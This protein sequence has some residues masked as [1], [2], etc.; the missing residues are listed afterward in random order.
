MKL[1]SFHVENF[2][3]LSDFSYD[4]KEGFNS[5]HMENGMGKSTFAAFIRVMF[6]G[7][8]GESKRGEFENERR[9]YAP[10]QNGTYGGQLTFSVGKKTYIISRVF[11]KTAKGD[12][13]RLQDA[14]TMLDS[15]DYSLNIGEELLQIDAASFLRT[16][17]VGQA[18]CAECTATDSISAKLGNLAENTD[19]INNFE[20][21]DKRM[22]DML[23]SLSAKRSTGKIAKLNKE[24]AQI[25][26]EVRAKA[27]LEEAMRQLG[28][29][30]E[31]AK[32][33]KE[34]L[35]LQQTEMQKKFEQASR[36]EEM[37]TKQEQYQQLVQDFEQKQRELET[38]GAYFS[39]GLPEKQE[40]S[41]MQKY[42]Q[43]LSELEK[44]QSSRELSASE[45]NKLSLYEQK[46][47]SG[48][49]DTEEIAE[50][51]ELVNL[52]R[53]LKSMLSVKTENLQAEIAREDENRQAKKKHNLQISI[54]FTLIGIALITAGLLAP[55]L[56][57]G[58]R[59]VIF[60][61]A[62]GM[63][64]FSIY[65]IR[66]N[67]KYMDNPALVRMRQACEEDEEK[68]A[69]T[70]RQ[71]RLFFAKLQINYE[72][73][74]AGQ[75]L[76]V[77]KD[78]VWEYGNL[79][80]KKGDALTEEE[81]AEYQ[82][83]TELLHTFLQTYVEAPTEPTS[84]IAYMSLLK[85]MEQ[86]LSAYEKIKHEYEASKSRKCAWEEKQQ[87]QPERQSIQDM[88]QPDVYK[89]Q[90]ASLREQYED[91]M[92]VLAEYTR[93]L[94]DK[95]EEFDGLIEK[96]EKLESL[97]EEVISLTEKCDIIKKTQ[98][99]LTKAKESFTA[100]YTK[101]LLD[102][103]EKYYRLISDETAG[104]YALD[105]NL[106]I[107][108]KEQGIYRD[109]RHMSS[110][111]Q[112]LIGL[113]MRMAMVDAMYQQEK[114]FIILDDPFVNLDE[115]KLQGTERFLEKLSDNYQVIYFTCHESRAW[116]ERA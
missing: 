103:F 67:S 52:C 16:V 72:E 107:E 80:A 99:F 113:C 12:V 46:F 42:V 49:P 2:G 94:D 39:G 83:K 90:L 75:T 98:T 53:Q 20:V 114:P 45:L 4:F 23:N 14:E 24:I 36:Q 35:L 10:W 40:L 8:Q 97:R 7:F 60:V 106:N 101:P 28:E 92:H 54:I 112:D 66:K 115:K 17:Y 96:E 43:R 18:E 9:F 95:T 1:L 79:S 88:E 78:E 56:S 81:L 76:Q 82:S 100:R 74:K 89:E 47:A 62:I 27:A 6:F 55:P 116:S 19:D 111:Y 61:C 29:K 26:E 15:H 108:R 84:W 65:T 41:R 77:L 31:E 86:R 105:A 50:K 63:I 58:V 59:I 91:E 25:T 38:A 5:I 110:G 22:T 32:H 30:R 68:I 93:Q 87:M 3:K 104:A 34:T 11:G 21:V 109:M 57:I 37:R 13:F 71:I 85:D 102:G 33:K 69:E 44:K 48:V 73:E 64:L 51:Q 70:E